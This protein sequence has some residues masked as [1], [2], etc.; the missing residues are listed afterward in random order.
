[1]TDKCH[2]QNWLVQPGKSQCKDCG[3]IPPKRDEPPRPK[4]T[5][6]K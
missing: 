3:Y 5:V 6:V 2:H 1:M 4:L